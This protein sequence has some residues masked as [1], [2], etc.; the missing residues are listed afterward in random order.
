[1]SADCDVDVTCATGV[2]GVTGKVCADFGMDFF[3]LFRIK[4]IIPHIYIPFLQR[5]YIYSTAL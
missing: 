5:G 1:M 3:R 2:S 4:L